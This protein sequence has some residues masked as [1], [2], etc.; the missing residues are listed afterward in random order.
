MSPSQRYCHGRVAFL[1]WRC[2]LNLAS[3]GSM[4]NRNAKPNGDKIRDLRRL[5]GMTQHILGV[6]SGV[7][8]RTVQRAEAGKPMQMESL[9]NIASALNV[10]LRQILAA[11]S[12]GAEDD[13]D[14]LLAQSLIVLRPTQSGMALINTVAGSFDGKISC[15]A[16]PTTDNVDVLTALTS[17]LEGM[18]P[19]PWRTPME[20]PE[21]PLSARL[22]AAVAISGQ[23]EQLAGFGIAVFNATYTA[24]AQIPYYDMDEGHMSVSGRSPYELV[25]LC[26]IIIAPATRD[27]ISLKVD[28]LYVPPKAPVFEAADLED[29]PF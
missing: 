4:E 5:A 13:A 26:R 29:I 22:R 2:R 6:K 8:Q 17:A 16:E 24:K 15:E 21:F 18:M 12:D 7:D 9:S 1:T 25:T 19:D 23:I 11:L 10:P 14:A 20:E 27:R 3:L 28:D